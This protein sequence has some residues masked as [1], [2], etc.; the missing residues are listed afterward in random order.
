MTMRVT[1]TID[2][3]V[4]DFLTNFGGANRS[5]YV[6]QLLK[7]EKQRILEEAIR[8]ANQEEAEDPEYQKELSVWEETLSDGLKP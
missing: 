8:K 5:A 6:N 4:H 7:R 2:D 1:F 3:E